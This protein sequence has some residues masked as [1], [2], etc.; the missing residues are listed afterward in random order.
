M[1]FRLPPIGGGVATDI[2]LDDALGPEPGMPAGD[3]CPLVATATGAVLALRWSRWPHPERIAATVH[4]DGRGAVGWAAQDAAG[5]WLGAGRVPDGPGAIE[6]AQAL[7]LRVLRAW[8][9]DGGT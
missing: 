3:W 8:A 6:E 2:A 9:R 4:R 7:A 5:E 1:A